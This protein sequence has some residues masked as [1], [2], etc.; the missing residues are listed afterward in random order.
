MQISEEVRIR[1]RIISSVEIASKCGQA[2]SMREIDLLLPKQLVPANSRT[3]IQ[4]DPVA[5]KAVSV[6]DELVVLKGYENLFAE[7]KLRERNAV[8][9]QKAAKDF[10]DE[11]VGGSPH[12]KLVAVCGSVAYGSAKDTDDIDLFLITKRNRMWLSLLRALVL[13]RAFSLKAALVGGKANFC[14]SYIQDQEQFEEAMQKRRNPLFAREFLSLNVVRGSQYYT[15]LMRRLGWI[16]KIFP[17][18]YTLKLGKQ[19]KVQLNSP[20]NE[21]LPIALDTLNL[22]IFS[23]LKIYLSFKAY[24]RNL[25]YLKQKKS[26]DV[27]E[28]VI[29]KGS[30]IYTSRRYRELENMYSKQSFGM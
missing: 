28:A 8:R 24:L 22:S 10:I 13:A 2:L 14:L 5:S 12:V 29:S 11:L 9:D 18:L 19:T 4:S 27:F 15:S 6:N 1:E 7:R 30:C 21:L 16:R 23:L 25:K 20:K 3:V 17:R 26:K